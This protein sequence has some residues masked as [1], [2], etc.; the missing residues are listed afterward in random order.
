MCVY[1]LVESMIGRSTP[2]RDMLCLLEARI[3]R[4]ERKRR[5]QTL[6]RGI[7]LMLR[8]GGVWV[9]SAD[10]HHHKLP[11][12]CHFIVCL[13]PC[14]VATTLG[15]C[16][17]VGYCGPAHVRPACVCPRNRLVVD[18]DECPTCV[19]SALALAGAASDAHVERLVLLLRRRAQPQTHKTSRP[20]AIRQRRLR[21][22]AMTR[23]HPRFPP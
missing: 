5:S 16:K 6:F 20:L 9:H 22:I 1:K 7:F 21:R 10:F 15:A 23:I 14:S 11:I 8:R 3:S 2:L 4:I 18:A 13:C 17:R 19:G 12:S